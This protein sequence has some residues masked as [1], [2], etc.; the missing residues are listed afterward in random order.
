MKILIAD[1]SE[2]SRFMLKQSLQ[3]VGN[4]VILARNGQEALDRVSQ[5]PVDLI[6]SAVMRPQM[7]GF[8]LCHALKNNAQLKHIPFVFYSADYVDE[9]DQ[10]FALQL[11]AARY[12]VKT[13]DVDGFVSQL[14]DLLTDEMLQ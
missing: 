8:Q 12:L 7:D 13:A 1:D 3:K 5:E 10:A 2:L 6:I 14:K 11:G 4:E 9:K